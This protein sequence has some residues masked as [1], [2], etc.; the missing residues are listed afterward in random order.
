VGCVLGVFVDCRHCQ[1]DMQEGE[2][3]RYG[4]KADPVAYIEPLNIVAVLQRKWEMQ[5]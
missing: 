1:S 3:G 4:N 5:R 2:T